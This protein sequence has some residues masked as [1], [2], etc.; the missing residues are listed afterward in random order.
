[1]QRIVQKHATDIVRVAFAYVKNV[2]DAQDI[3]QEVFYACLRKAPAFMDA[4]HEKA[5]LL[6]VTVNKSRDFL[7]S[8]W[9]RRRVPLT[10]E[11]PAM[12]E[13]E[14]GLLRAALSLEEKYRLPVYLHYFAGYSLREIAV[15][16]ST[17]PS[18]V[19]TWLDRGKRQLRERLEEND[20]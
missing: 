11:L 19:G 5:W 1:M 4:A 14:G 9:M 16:L 2:H 12:P 18:T 10:E 20:G 15:M 7:R 6:R 17:N 8:A 13:E 3:A